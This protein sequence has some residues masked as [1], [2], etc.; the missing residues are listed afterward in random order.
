MD[1]DPTQNDMFGELKKARKNKKR[2]N[3]IIKI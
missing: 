1:D 2:K 3:K